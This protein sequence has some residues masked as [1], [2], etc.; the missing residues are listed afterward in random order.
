MSRLASAT[1]KPCIVAGAGALAASFNCR[2]QSASWRMVSSRSRISS[3]LESTVVTPVVGGVFGK[4]NLFSNERLKCLDPCYRRLNSSA[5][6]RLND[7]ESFFVVLV[8]AFRQQP[9]EPAV[10]IVVELETG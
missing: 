9:A 4:P 3:C 2:C 1:A 6:K 10:V 7:L 5:V 8:C